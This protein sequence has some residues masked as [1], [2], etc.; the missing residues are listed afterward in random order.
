MKGREDGGKYAIP[1][2]PFL[3]LCAVLYLFIGPGV[4]HAVN[5]FL[6]KR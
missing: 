4:V 3:S 2:G 6:L 1:F 5:E